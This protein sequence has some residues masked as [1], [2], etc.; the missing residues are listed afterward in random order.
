I[1]ARTPSKRWVDIEWAL[2]WCYCDELPKRDRAAMPPAVS[3]HHV[4][5]PYLAPAGYGDSPM[6]RDGIGGGPSGGYVEGWSRDPGFPLALGGP[7]P[8]AI[9]IEQAVKGLATWA[10]HSFGAD[11]AAG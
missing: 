8:D 1:V 2:R 7:H 4:W 9:A 3:S 5:S 10:G 6:F 11:D